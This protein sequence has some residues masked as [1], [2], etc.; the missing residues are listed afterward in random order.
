MRIDD[1]KHNGLLKIGEV[2]VDNEV[3]DSPVVQQL[4]NAV[5]LELSKRSY[6]KDVKYSIDYVE[7]TTYEQQ[8]KAYKADDV[9]RTLTKMGVASK[10][11]DKINGEEAD[12]WFVADPFE[13]LASVKEAIRKIKAGN[14]AGYGAIKFRP[15]QEKAISETV[16]QFQKPKGKAFLWN[17]KMRFGKT[18]SGLEVAKRCDYKSTLIITHRP[19][20]DK[21]WSD[22]FKKIFGNDS[23]YA[24]GRRMMDDRDSSGDF[25]SLTKAVDAGNKRLVFFVSMQYLRLSQFVGGKEKHFDPLKRAIMEYDWDFVMVDEA[26]EGIEAAAGVR[27]MNKLRKENTRILSLSGTPFNLLDK[28]EEGEIYT[29]DYVMEQKAKQ[30]WDDKHFGDP[31]P[32]ADLPRMQILTFTLPKMVREEAIENN[33]I[34]KF[35]EFFRVW[36]EAD[37]QS[38]QNLMDN[39]TNTVRKAELKAQIDNIQIDKFIHEGAVRCFVKKL[40]TNSETSQYP[41]STDEFRDKFRHTFWLLP[42]VKEAAALEEILRED[43]VFGKPSMFHIIN[44]AGDGNIEDKD[45]SA[46]ADVEDNIRGYDP[47][48]DEDKERAKKKK[49]VLAKKRTITLSCGKLTTGVSVPE[50]TAVLCMKG[51]ENTPAANYIQTIFRVQTHAT[52][53]GRQ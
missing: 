19:V 14:G 33:E 11:L 38:L 49:A 35:H 34:F 31:N 4:A 6:M 3:A 12:I 9:Y 20:V 10:A 41:F 8:T 39:E 29:W 43:K 37:R 5:R 27:V 23:R 13:P 2:F 28:Y 26:H 48:Q 44:A 22:D 1:R 42:G 45:G 51:S 24:Y 25:Y 40:R 21:G 18:L 15:E 53:D 30:E 32:Y 46:L 16:K 17:A 7:C 47:N 52:L 50:W 36:T